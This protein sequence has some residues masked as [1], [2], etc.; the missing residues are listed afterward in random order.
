MLRTRRLVEFE[1]RIIFKKFKYKN[2]PEVRT[3]LG[4]GSKLCCNYLKR[5]FNA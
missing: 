3:S 2:N 1:Y 4:L 5:L